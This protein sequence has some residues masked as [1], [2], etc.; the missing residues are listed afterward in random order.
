MMHRNLNLEL[1]YMDDSPYRHLSQELLTCLPA[2]FW[3]SS[4][5]AVAT[6]LPADRVCDVWYCKVDERLAHE[7]CTIRNPCSNPDPGNNRNLTT[8]SVCCVPSPA[9]T[10]PLFGVSV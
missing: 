7:T 2:G 9:A 1:Y 10:T 3:S 8:M 4:L 5:K 6:D